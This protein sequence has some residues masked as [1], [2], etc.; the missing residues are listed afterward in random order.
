MNSSAS[1]I[2]EHAFDVATAQIAHSI[3][4]RSFELCI[5]GAAGISSFLFLLK[6]I[7]YRGEK[8]HF[9]IVGYRWFWEPTWLLRLRFLTNSFSILNDGYSKVKMVDITRQQSELIRSSTKMAYS[10]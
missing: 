1:V 9:P 5:L 4:E 8:L 6:S 7:F 2:F 10:S 3:E